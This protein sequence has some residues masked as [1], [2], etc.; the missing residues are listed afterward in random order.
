MNPTQ[1]T[2]IDGLCEKMGALEGK[3]KELQRKLDEIE[4]RTIC[5]YCHKEYVTKDPLTPSL[6]A[7]HV[8]TCEKSPLVKLINNAAILNV[9][10]EEE[11]DTLKQQLTTERKVS[12]LYH[13]AWIGYK[14]FPSLAWERKFDEAELL[15]AELRPTKK[16]GYSV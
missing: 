4:G 13:K 11:R 7:D 14:V 6:L 12:D 8:L 9:T 16:K 3:N 10:L 2:A 5:A 15:H 1:T